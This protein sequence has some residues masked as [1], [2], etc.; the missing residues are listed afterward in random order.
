ML[1]SIGFSTCWLYNFKHSEPCLLFLIISVVPKKNAASLLWH[2]LGLSE[3]QPLFLY[4]WPIC[5]YFQPCH[6]SSVAKV[7][8]ES[9]LCRNAS[10][11]LLFLSSLLSCSIQW[12]NPGRDP[13]CPV[14]IIH[15][16]VC[17]QGWCRHW[18]FVFLL[19]QALAIV[20]GSPCQD[21]KWWCS[22]ELRRSVNYF[23]IFH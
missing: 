3:R 13:F 1:A 8:A 20:T 6:G 14:Q 21:S 10:F 16:P 7:T 4:Q 17:V 2:S 22:F 19:S 18:C 5:P 23:Q 12:R 15:P 11:I 9:K